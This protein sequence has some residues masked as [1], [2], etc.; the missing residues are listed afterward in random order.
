[1][2][3]DGQ[4]PTRNS[5]LMSGRRQQAL[6]DLAVKLFMG[7]GHAGQVTSSRIA[8]PKRGSAKI[9]TP[10][11]DCRR[12]AQVRRAHHEEERVLHL[13]VQPDDPGQAAEDL[14]LAALLQDRGVPAACALDARRT[15]HDVASAFETGHAELPQEL[16]ALIT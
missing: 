10:A 7:V 6:F 5:C 4:E 3:S 13:A 11:A 15:V 9:I 8:V 14:P 12:C 1:M 16:P 2:T